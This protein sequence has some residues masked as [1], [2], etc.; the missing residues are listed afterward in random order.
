MPFAETMEDLLIVLRNKVAPKLNQ[1]IQELQK[2][3]KQNRLEIHE[4]NIKTPDEEEKIKEE[5]PKL[6]AERRNTLLG[7]DNLELAKFVLQ[8]ELVKIRNSDE[9]NQDSLNKILDFVKNIDITKKI[10]VS[11]IKQLKT[12][13]NQIMEEMKDD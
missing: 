5:S 3:V 13:L 12:M 4:K 8:E 1:H 6:K 11:T 7:Q 2:T 10:E 9:R